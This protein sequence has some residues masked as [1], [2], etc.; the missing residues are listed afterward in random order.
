MTIKHSLAGSFSDHIEQLDAYQR[1]IQYWGVMFDR[2]NR[3][4]S[5]DCMNFRLGLFPEVLSLAEAHAIHPL[6][7]GYASPDG[8][9]EV[10]ALIRR[11]EYLRLQRHSP[12]RERLNLDL[13][14][15]AG[16]GCGVGTTGAI[17]AVMK[18]ILRLPRSQFPR[19]NG[20]PE[21]VMV[22]PNSP[23]CASQLSHTQ[24]R[25]TPR[26]VNARMENGYLA[27]FD[28]ITS[29]V[30]PRTVQIALTYP[31]NPAQATY[32]GQRLDDLRRLVQFCQNEGIFLLVDN[33]Y[34]ELVHGEGRRFE[35][36]FAQTDRLD[37]LVKFYGPS[38]DTPNFAGH[39]IGYWFGDPRLQGGCREHTWVAANSAS[40][41]AMAMFGLNLLLRSLDYT[42]EEL[43]PAHME[44][45]E[46]GIFGWAQRVD[47]Q[48]CLDRFEQTGLSGA[49]RRRLQHANQLQREALRQIRAFVDASDTF[50][51]VCN[52]DIGNVCLLKVAP[53][54]FAGSDVELFEALFDHGIAILPGNAFG[55]PI[56]RGDA[57]FRMTVV[58]EPIDHLLR[59]L[60]RVEVALAGRRDGRRPLPA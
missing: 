47:R 2:R 5:L 12:H 14:R 60:E 59:L 35:E 30:T 25:L 4:A 15:Q 18:A 56:A 10:G 53:H 42:G 40:P 36:L 34:Q 49:F 41:V 9:P 32:E 54:R 16:L 31:N 27:T 23:V 37:Y 39:R 38:K 24:P 11:L 17:M 57:C 48:E 33:V 29:Q 21:A 28:E 20:Q 51:H 19:A 6:E 43:G 55:L 58:H 50:E 8:E 1:L 52:E 44:Y 13:V 3:L 7:S 22:V 26:L 46:S 45:L